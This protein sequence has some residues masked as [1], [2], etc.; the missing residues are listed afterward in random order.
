MEQIQVEDRFLQGR[1]KAM[2][3]LNYKDRTEWELRNKL[4]QAEFEEDVIEDAVA[5]VESFHYIDDERY[6]ANFVLAHR[7]SKSIQRMQQELKRRHVAEEVIE[8]AVS[9]VCGDDS[10]A[11]K[12]A[13]QKLLKASGGELGQMPYREKQKLAAKLYRRGFQGEDISR[14]LQL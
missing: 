1:K 13:V 9:S 14:E 6:A 3:L 7:D 12:K 5:Y 11:L 4:S 8:Q 10:G 2:A